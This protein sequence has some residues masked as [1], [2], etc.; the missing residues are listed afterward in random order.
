MPAAKTNPRRARH[1]LF[2]TMTTGP[3]TRS[4]LK[5]DFRDD[6]FYSTSGDAIKAIWGLEGMRRHTE[7]A[8][9]KV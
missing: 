5:I 2:A 9:R 7:A 4:T 8:V 1:D 6:C 3:H